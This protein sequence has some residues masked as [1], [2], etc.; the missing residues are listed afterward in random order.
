MWRNSLRIFVL[1]WI[2]RLLIESRTTRAFRSGCPRMRNSTFS[3]MFSSIVGLSTMI[4]W[5]C[6]F[7]WDIMIWLTQS[8]NQMWSIGISRTSRALMMLWLGMVVVTYTTSRSFFIANRSSIPWIASKYWSDLRCNATADE[9]GSARSFSAISLVMLTSTATGHA[10]SFEQRDEQHAGGR[11]VQ[12][13]LGAAVRRAS[14]LHDLQ[15]PQEIA[16]ALQVPRHDDAVGQG[17]LNA[18]LG[19]AVLGRPDLG[20]EEGRTPLR[21]QDGAQAEEEISDPLLLSDAVADRGHGVEDQAADLLFLHDAG[22]R[23]REQSGLVEIEVLFVDAELVVDLR[24]VDELELALPDELV[25]EEVERDDVHQELVRRLRDAQVE[26]ILAAQ[27][28]P[29]QEL[30]ADRG[31]AGAHGS[32]DEDG[33]P[34]RAPA[35]QDVVDRV[36]AGHASLALVVGMFRCGHRFGRDNPEGDI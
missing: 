19:V 28:A 34:P 33:V 18:P 31:L 23:V 10:P 35:I 1:L 8:T 20:D 4:A 17:L 21:A 6:R 22:D 25:V 11:Q 7:A 9:S 14:H 12:D 16:P 13:V 26:A 2:A 30:D 27:R 36:D 24:E 32:G 29:D 3:M 15:G 5:G